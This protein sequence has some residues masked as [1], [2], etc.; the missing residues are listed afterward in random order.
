MWREDRNTDSWECLCEMK[1]KRDTDSGECLCE[2]KE[3]YRQW[4]CLCEV[5]YPVASVC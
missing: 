5:K 4:E 1:T 2:D 3:W